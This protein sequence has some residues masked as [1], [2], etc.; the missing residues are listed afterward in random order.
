[1]N[2]LFLAFC[3]TIISSVLAFAQSSSDYKKAEGYVGYSNNQV[4]TGFNSN[5]G[6]F[7]SNLFNDRRSF[8]GVEVAGVYNVHR[9]VG[10]K[11][12]FSAAYRKE[13]F[14]FSTGTGTTANTISGETR[15]QLYNYLGGVQIKDNSSDA[16]FK[17]FAHAL[18]GAATGRTKFRNI[19]CTNTSAA[20]GCSTIIANG[21]ASNDTETAF[22]GAFGGG[23]DIKLGDHVDLR[24][25]QVDYNPIR[26][27]GGTDNN[28]R[29]GIGLVFK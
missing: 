17:P 28:F 10:L 20:S 21:L 11:A 6:S 26:F 24:A 19:T 5:S 27:N 12:D 7:S 29:F 23:L 4:D 25:I 16:R 1:M 15:N 9:Y 8:N 13:N 14:S 2:K 18:V 22:A 3:L